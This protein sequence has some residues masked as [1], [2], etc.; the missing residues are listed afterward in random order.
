MASDRPTAA[1]PARAV[2][3][4]AVL[5]AAAGCGSLSVGG[6]TG[7]FQDGYLFTWTRVPYST[8]LHNTP[9]PRREGGGKIIRITEPVSGY[10]L[11]V[12]F[13]SNA[14]GDI[15]RANGITTVYFADIE[16]FDI[17]GI[18]THHEVLIYGE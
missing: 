3:L 2:A 5:L 8:H 16:T 18:W 9:A 12:E 13:N 14:I 6:A 4:L 1:R 17:L 10:D 11:S 15:A 7:D